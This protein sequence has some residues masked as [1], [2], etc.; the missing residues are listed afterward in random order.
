[1]KYDKCNNCKKEIRR[2]DYVRLNSNYEKISNSTI[3]E[4]K[5]NFSDPEYICSTE[6]KVCIDCYEKF[7]KDK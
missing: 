1:M 2:D 7:Y 6:I 3:K 5:N 4:E